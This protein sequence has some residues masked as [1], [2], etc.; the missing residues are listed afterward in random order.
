MTEPAVQVKWRY[1]KSSN[2]LA[3]GWDNRDHLYV[4]F[5]GGGE[6]LYDGVSRQRAVACA[7]AKS[8]G[9]Y[10]N[11]VIKPAFTAVRLA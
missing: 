6:Y 1:V 2:V 10:I 4:R 3:V 9:S 8:V 7:R 5:Q 11:K